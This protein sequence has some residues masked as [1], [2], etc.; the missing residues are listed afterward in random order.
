MFPARFEYLV[1]ESFEHASLELVRA[2]AGAKVLAGGCSL[3]PLMKLRLA[4]PSVLIDLNRIRDAAYVREAEGGAEGGLEIGALTRESDIEASAAIRRD[5]PILADTSGVIADPLVRNMG[6]VGGNLAHADPA[7]DHPAT[8]LALHAQVVAVSARGSRT[9]PVDE[10]FVDLFETALE[11][12]EILTRISL[13]PS[14]PGTGSA[15]V[16]L[17]RQV[18]DFP[19]VGAAVVMRVSGGIVRHA[20]ICL[21]N[22]APVP[23]RAAT[24]EAVLLGAEPGDAVL[25]EAAARAVDD[26]SPWSELRGSASY[27]LRVVPVVVRRA[28]ERSLGRVASAATLAGDA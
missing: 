13:P 15:Y 24:A 14:P 12:D 2:G 6:T 27:K 10:F 21:T 23:V 7:N 26:L 8:M 11:T 16:K 1:A 20:S 5:Y 22:V 18:G 28:L 4:E 17:E 3:I 25:R 9:I 19:V